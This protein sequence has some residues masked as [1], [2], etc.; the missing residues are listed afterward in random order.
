M[1]VPIDVAI[2]VDVVDTERV[3]RYNQRIEEKRSQLW[4]LL[5]VRGRSTFDLLVGRPTLT[6]HRYAQTELPIA[7]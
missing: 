1:R 3:Y 4:L 2:A 6:E 7:P 5:C